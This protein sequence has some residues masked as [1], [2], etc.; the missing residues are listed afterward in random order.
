MLHF[1]QQNDPP[2]NREGS[3][4]ETQWISNCQKSET[5]FGQIN[6]NSET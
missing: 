5:F 2:H 6:N 4:K 1:F 3:V